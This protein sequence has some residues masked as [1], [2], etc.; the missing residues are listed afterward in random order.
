MADLARAQGQRP[1]TV[2]ANLNGKRPAGLEDLVLWS[3][4]AGEK[5]V[6]LAPPDGLAEQFAGV[7]PELPLP[8]AGGG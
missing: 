7:R 2:G 1:E 8:K 3:W 5:V 4:L 6:R